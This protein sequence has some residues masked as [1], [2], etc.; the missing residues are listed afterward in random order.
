MRVIAVA[1]G[2]APIDGAP[3]DLREVSFQMVGIVGFWD[4]MRPDVP[5]AMATCR[6][7]GI[8]V[9]MITGDHAETAR[10]IA[11]AS[12]LDAENVL[13]GLEIEAMSDSE[14]AERL[15]TTHV[16]ARA[17]PAHK[18]RIVRALRE[19][20]LVIGMTG[21]GVNDAPALKTADVGIAMGARGTDVAREAASLVLEDDAF[22][23]IVKAVRMGRRIYDN[24]RKAFAYIVAVHV[25][26]AGMSLVP[27][28]FGWPSV[29]APIH[30][31]ILELIIDPACSIVLEVDPEEPD[32]M[33]RRPRSK[34]A[35]LLDGRRFL[36]AV[37][38]GT[39]VLLGILTVVALSA[40]DQPE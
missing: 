13:S 23:S 30:V 12:S 11:R 22:G 26:I 24:L 28:L 33:T 9:L 20:G 35:R 5:R 34:G 3:D 17:V 10:A 39:V 14:L 29:I 27:A 15:S 6:N 8:R 18:L 37:L 2:S 1:R 32:V 7:A 38:S 16:V 36:R 40:R 25:P 4:P 19:N 31:V 21:D